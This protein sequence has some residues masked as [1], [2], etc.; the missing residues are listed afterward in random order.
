MVQRTAPGKGCGVSR[1]ECINYF[2]LTKVSTR[3]NF[4]IAQDFLTLRKH[5]NSTV[6]ETSEVVQHDIHQLDSIPRLSHLLPKSL[7]V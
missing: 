2:P 5:D 7:Q 6:M 4:L 3:E 1:N